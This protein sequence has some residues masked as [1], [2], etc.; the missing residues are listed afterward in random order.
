MTNKE[1]ENLKA[2]I[3][4]LLAKNVEN[5]A[6]EAEAAMALEKA[7]ELMTKYMIAQ[8]ELDIKS[9][10]CLKLEV[11][12]YPSNYNLYF[13]HKPI[14]ELFDCM[15]WMIGKNK[16]KRA[17]YF[18]FD[19]DTQLASYFYNYLC[20]MI[21]TEA[22]AYKETE[23]YK[24]LCQNR[25]GRSVIADFIQGLQLRLIQRI[26]EQ[27]AKKRKTVDET[28]SRDL[29]V[30]KSGVVNQEF[31]DLGINLKSKSVTVRN[32]DTKAYKAGHKRGGEVEITQGIRGKSRKQKAVGVA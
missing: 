16:D 28:G 10:K 25:H 13:I 21:V 9:T 22:A 17:I 8:S 3:N 4:A 12:I 14:A 32:Q 1:K 23:E 5:G 20:R 2:K 27:I 19:E 18:G 30:V 6:T 31:V 7:Q 26:D 24:R 11:E 29:V 15:V